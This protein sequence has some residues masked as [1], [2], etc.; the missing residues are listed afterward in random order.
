MGRKKLK[1]V[2]A[3]EPRGGRKVVPHSAGAEARVGD[4]IAL[5]WSQARVWARIYGA[6]LGWSQAR[7]WNDIAL[8]WS[9]AR[10]WGR[11]T[12]WG[13]AGV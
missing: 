12:N 1:E 9:Q 5:G 7:V 8:G 3:P 2:G 6:A 13:R 11:C 10:V 4:D